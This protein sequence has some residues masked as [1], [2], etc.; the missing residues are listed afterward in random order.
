MSVCIKSSAG[1][2][3]YAMSRMD[4]SGQYQNPARLLITFHIGYFSTYTVLH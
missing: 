2:H 1:I 4:A 3:I